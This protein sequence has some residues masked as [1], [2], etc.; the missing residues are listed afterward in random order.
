MITR[1][2]L[3]N[4]KSVQ[5]DTALELGPLTIFAGP[6]SSGKSTCI[7]SML[8]ICQTLRNQIG[9]RSVILNGTLTRLGQFSDL[10][11]YG[12]DANQILIGWELR[13]AW[14]GRLAAQEPYVT[15]EEDGLIFEGEDGPLVSLACEVGFDAKPDSPNDVTQL[16]PQL[17]STLIRTTRRD[18]DGVDHLTAV[19][20]SRSPD[21]GELQISRLRERGM[22]EVEADRVGSAAAFRIDLDDDSIH[23]LKRRFVSG[24]VVGC[25][26]LH[27]LPSRIALAYN[28]AEE[29]ISAL[30]NV[31]FGTGRLPARLRAQGRDLYIPV[32]GLRVLSR[33]LSS[34]SGTLFESHTDLDRLVLG[35]EPVALSS[36]Q[37]ALRSL[38]ISRKRNFQEEVLSNPSF[39]EEF[40]VAAKSDLADQ[41][42]TAFAQPGR[43][44]Q[45]SCLY[46]RR[47]FSQAVKYLGPLRDE[48]KALYALSSGSDPFDVGLQGENTAA[49]LD[50]HK[51]KLIRFV[52]PG[53]FGQAA[54][55]GEAILRTLQVAVGEWLRY[56]GV[57][58]SAE[59]I[60]KGKL[61][62]ELK[63]R[64][65]RYSGQQDLTHVGV[66]V[67][68]VLPILVMCLLADRDSV[69]VFEQPELHLHPRVQ[70]LLGD[71]FLSMALM[72]KQCII[73][74]HSEYLISRLRFRAAAATS[75]EVAGRIKMY[76][77]EKHEASSSFRQVKINQFGAIE[78]WPE[79][80]FDQSQKEAEATL[81][82]AMQKRRQAQQRKP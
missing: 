77:V 38:P 48:P 1:W 19:G 65:D 66:G 53:A 55:A 44:L 64:V 14:A 61:G 81:K 2:R 39:A 35:E 51:S 16:N 76:F 57:A 82:A 41:F 42:R 4:F 37:E 75:D 30:T 20:L 9:S 36:F 25:D 12:G 7:Q 56:L 72:D 52:P 24:E 50:L 71:F 54:V 27:F 70:T 60:D 67:S 23:E 40:A 3:F 21:G 59:S 29:H 10:K 68:Q 69:L 74:T 62:H 79:G 47:Y 43:G 22:A 63:V 17:F 13:P 34:S 32:S 31:I 5:S 78:D 26:L 28:A 33:I 46:M 49:V 73:E 45:M 6:N 8:L 58:D 15:W 11:S 18:V 80:F